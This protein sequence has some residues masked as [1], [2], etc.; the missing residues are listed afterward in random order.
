M[1]ILIVIIY[2]AW[3][4]FFGQFA[5]ANNLILHILFGYQPPWE[6]SLYIDYENIKIL[7]PNKYQLFFGLV[8]DWYIIQ[9]FKKV[10]RD[11]LLD[12]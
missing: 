4:A 7:I 9:F 8:I 1:K 11:D 10:K 5:F 12:S 2:L 3:Y 6:G